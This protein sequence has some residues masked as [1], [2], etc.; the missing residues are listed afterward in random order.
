MTDKPLI[1]IVT[2]SFNQGR[3]LRST[4]HSVLGQHG[5]PLE[6]VIIDGG[7][8]DNSISI[9]EEFAADPRLIYWTSE[10]DSGQYDAINKGFAHTNG[11]IMAWLNSDDMYLP[12]ALKIVA[13]IFDRFQQIDWLTTT[14]HIH[15][16]DMDEIVLCR[17]IGGYNQRAFWRGSHLL[18]QDWFAKTII[19]QES[20]FW[21]RSLWERVGG[22][23]NTSYELAADFE[24]WTRFYRHTDLYAVDVPLGGIR[25]HHLQ[26]TARGMDQYLL[27]ARAVFMNAGGKPYGRLQ[28]ALRKSLWY[29]AGYRSYQKLSPTLGCFL[30]KSGLFY[31]TQV[32]VWQD[33][34]WRLTNDY[35]I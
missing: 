32:C 6:Y 20:T 23:V 24:L 28:S 25:K 33:G 1:S 27:E 26:K 35:T 15:Y 17:Y 21:R 7:S 2:P 4:I 14:Q 16:N 31:P 13:N 8:Q 22:F 29:A 34:Q 10:K 9:I 5:F 12:G 11:E 19:Q 3:F 18:G 30:V